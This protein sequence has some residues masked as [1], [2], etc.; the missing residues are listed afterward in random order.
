MSEIISIIDRLGFPTFVCIAFGWYI[1]KRD[2]Q[3]LE[4]EKE[5]K[6]N[7]IEERKKLAESIEL[8]RKT[9]CELLTTNKE[10]SETNRLLSN[11]IVA[12]MN[13]MENTL[14][15]INNKIS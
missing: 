12:R 7:E 3:R 10:L 15:E 2:A 4:M 8:Y 13:I 11:E 9:S 14:I 1:N 6:Q 5:T